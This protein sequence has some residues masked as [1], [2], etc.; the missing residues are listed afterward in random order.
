MTRPTARQTMTRGKALLFSPSV[1]RRLMAQ[2]KA[3]V[4]GKGLS[5]SAIKKM[6]RQDLNE[7]IEQMF[8]RAKADVMAKIIKRILKREGRKAKTQRKFI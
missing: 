2:I 6:Q 1:K 4:T 7:I 3:N 5:L 8:M